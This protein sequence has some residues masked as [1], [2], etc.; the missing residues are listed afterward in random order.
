EVGVRSLQPRA[1]SAHLGRRAARRLPGV[2]P[3]AL[4][5]MTGPNY[6]LCAAEVYGG[7]EDSEGP[8]PGGL[9]LPAAEAPASSVL[10]LRCECGREHRI[11]APDQAASVELRRMV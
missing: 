6:E 4:P 8:A 2:R 7:A 1:R 3:G 11:P 5:A 9:P 10:V